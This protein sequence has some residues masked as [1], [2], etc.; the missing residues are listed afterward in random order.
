[1]RAVFLVIATAGALPA[2]GGNHEDYDAWV[3]HCANCGPQ[4]ACAI[5]YGACEDQ[6]Y[7]SAWCVED[8]QACVDG[9]PQA[10]ESS[11]CLDQLPPAPFRIACVI[12]PSGTPILVGCD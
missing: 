1:M 5:S 10:C 6:R 7:E 9:G 11:A 3:K 2:C 8:P 12:G 4:H